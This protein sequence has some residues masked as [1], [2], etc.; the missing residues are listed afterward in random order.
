[1]RIL[2]LSDSHSKKSILETII[3]RHPDIDT[4]L[5]LGDGAK[6]FCSLKEFYPNKKMV[7]VRGNN[8]SSFLDLPDFEIVYIK[9]IKIFLTHG[10]LYHI[11]FG[12]ERVMEAA[13]KADCK[14]VLCGHTHIPKIHY[15]DGVYFVNPGSVSRS[16][17]GPN[18]YAVI[19]ILPNGQIFPVVMNV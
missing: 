13:A 4:V 19:D 9:N 3:E 5:F 17:S 2:V 10:H 7:A 11:S 8:D 12:R 15:E 14:I 16:R 6:E 1:M 18:S